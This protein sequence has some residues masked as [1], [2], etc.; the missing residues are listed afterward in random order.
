MAKGLIGFTGFVGG[1]LRTQTHF[2]LEYNSKNIND[3]TGKSFDLLVCAGVSAVKWKANKEPQQDWA[4]IQKLLKPLLTVQAKQLVLIS[5]IDV[6]PYPTKVDEQTSITIDDYPAYGKHRLQLE[7]IVEEQFPNVHIIRLPG[8]FG[9]GLK[10]NFIFDLHNNNC[11]DLV[12]TDSTFQFYNLANLWSDI[13][14]VVS[15]KIPLMNLNAEPV[16]AGDVAKKCFDLDFQTITEKPP[17]HYDVRT[18]H[19]TDFGK[20][21]AYVYSADYTFEQIRKFVLTEPHT[22][23]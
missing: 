5:T 9:P 19:A 21:G 7:R 13:Q 16:R 20:K 14:T 17:V 8:L 6:Y 3:L 23:V 15:K 10:K 22:S 2:D 11:L 4:G 12:H 1:N 18:I